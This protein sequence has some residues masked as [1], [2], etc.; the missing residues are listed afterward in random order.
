MCS[1]RV[2]Y[3]SNLLPL[4]PLAKQT[5]LSV[6]EALRLLWSGKVVEMLLKMVSFSLKHHQALGEAPF[7]TDVTKRASALPSREQ[8]IRIQNRRKATTR[9]SAVHCGY[10]LF[11]MRV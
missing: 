8:E 10:V 9:C 5:M 11:I 3:S 4:F 1:C 6:A 2:I 7:H